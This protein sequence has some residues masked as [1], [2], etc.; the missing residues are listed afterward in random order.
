MNVIGRLLTSGLL[1]CTLLSP[2]PALAYDWTVEG[3]VTLV[4]GSDL[5]TSLP[6]MVDTAAGSCAAGSF[7]TWVIRGSDATAKNI[8]IQAVY[9]MLMTAEKSSSKIRI[10]G[11]NSGCTVSF[12]YIL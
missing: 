5:P 11:N 12:I 6:F 8:N 1:T 10:T 2:V 9:A 3:H 7:L 4:E